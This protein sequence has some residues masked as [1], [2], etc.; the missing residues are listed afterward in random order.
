MLLS[1][2]LYLT[3]APATWRAARL[4]E[5]QPYV[6]DLPEGTPEGSPVEVTYAFDTAGRVHVT[7]RDVTSG[8][9][10]S[11]QIDRRGGLSDEQV[12]AYANLAAE[13]K[14]D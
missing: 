7:A 8:K 9:E 1:L 3:H 12:D 13:Y 2:D 6:H 5:D 4:V 11:I 10:A 14:V